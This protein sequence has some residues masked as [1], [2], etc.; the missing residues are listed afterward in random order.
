MCTSCSIYRTE[1]D[2]KLPREAPAL[3]H[4]AAVEQ[5]RRC[6]L[7]SPL[8]CVVPPCCIQPREAAGDALISRLAL[9][10]LV[11]TTAVGF[12]PTPHCFYHS[13]FLRLAL[14]FL[15]LLAGP[16]AMAAFP[17]HTLKVKTCNATG[18]G[19]L[20]QLH[21]SFCEGEHYCT[22][23]PP[24]LYNSA[25]ELEAVGIW[26]TLE[27][28]LEYEPATMYMTIVGDDSWYEANCSLSFSSF[29]QYHFCLMCPPN[30]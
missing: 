7:F 23:G 13:S 2:A 6:E 20:G 22:L 19:T 18:A 16:I 17:P 14:S 27:V 12:S 21:L 5:A 15:L 26:N 9:R 29:H 10:K 24:N 30:S 25:G 28:P 1:A 4:T 11:G 8:S 3:R